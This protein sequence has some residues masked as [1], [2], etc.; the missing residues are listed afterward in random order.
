MVASPRGSTA[1]GTGT[2]AKAPRAGSANAR[3][4][5]EDTIEDLILTRILGEKRGG[6]GMKDQERRA[7][8]RRGT[9]H[10]KKT[11]N[12]TV[13]CLCGTPPQRHK[14]L[15]TLATYHVSKTQN[16]RTPS[17][18]IHYYRVIARMVARCAVQGKR[19]NEQ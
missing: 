13:L 17:L 15:P 1:G 19:V 16:A 7:N 10:F 8:E 2:G 14:Q 12:Q 6:K 3:K 4:E 9:L 11:R 5:N 18:T